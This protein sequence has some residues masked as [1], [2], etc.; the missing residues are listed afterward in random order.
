MKIIK[1]QKLAKKINGTINKIKIF[2]HT[3]GKIKDT[4][5][6]LN[7]QNGDLKIT[8][9]NAKLPESRYKF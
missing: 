5:M 9:I 4:Q 3:F 1:I 7:F 2:R 6:K 8:D